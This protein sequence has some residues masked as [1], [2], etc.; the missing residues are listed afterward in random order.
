MPLTPAQLQT[1]KTHIAGNAA[2]VPINGVPT[3]ISAVPVSPDN[4]QAV[5]D[6]YNGAAAPAYKVWDTQVALKAIRSLVN[7][8]NYTPSDAAPAATNNVQGTNDALLYQNRALAC[9]LKQANAV[10]LVTGEGAIDCSPL[11]LRQN[12]N[13]CLTAIPSGVA[14]ANQNAGWGTSA[15]PGPVRLAMQRN[16]TSAEKLFAVASTAAP[17]A[18]NVGAD[19]RGAVTNPDTLAVVGALAGSDVLAAMTS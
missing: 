18:G 1:L 15:A 3:A 8:A 2:T 10:F 4:C 11:Q 6:W 19:A 17:N 5:A 9:Q 7:L 12:F 14:G 13:D 16:A